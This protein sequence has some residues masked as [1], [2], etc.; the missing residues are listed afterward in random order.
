V[1]IEE[2]L[3]RIE[4]MLNEIE[5]A[6]EGVTVEESTASELR[7]STATLRRALEKW[8]AEAPSAAVVQDLAAS[9]ADVLEKARVTRRAWQLF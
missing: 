4:S 8:R 5:E 3:V 1:G 6:L 2:E 7:T 9:V